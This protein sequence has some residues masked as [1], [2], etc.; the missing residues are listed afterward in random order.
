MYEEYKYKEN[1]T[2]AYHCKLKSQMQK[3]KSR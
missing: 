2:E 3:L 1:Y